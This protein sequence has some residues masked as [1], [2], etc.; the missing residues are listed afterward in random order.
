MHRIVKATI[1]IAAS[2]LL[3]SAAVVAAMFISALGSVPLGNWN[4]LL[5]VAALFAVF[6]AL[7]GVIMALD[8]SAEPIFLPMWLSAPFDAPATRTTICAALGAAA[9]LVVWS[10]H[11]HRFA[12]TWLVPGAAVGGALGW[13]GWRWAKYVDF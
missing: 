5:H 2:A 8:R 13:W 10:W 9:V 6:G 7:L 12:L 1:F 11:P 3:M 4:A